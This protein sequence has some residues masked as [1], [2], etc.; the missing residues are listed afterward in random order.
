MIWTKLTV[1]GT[2][3]DCGLGKVSVLGISNGPGRAGRAGSIKLGPR[4]GSG[5]AYRPFDSQRAG[6]G[7]NLIFFKARGQPTGFMLSGP[8]G[9]R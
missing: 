3:S 2:V 7:W 9:P 6:T 1:H 8:D 5:G 4:P